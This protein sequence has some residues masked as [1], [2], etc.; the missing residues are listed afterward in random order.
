MWDAVGLPWDTSK[1]DLSKMDGYGLHTEYNHVL[2]R[3]TKERT[4]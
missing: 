1:Y 2:Q 3:T 4:E